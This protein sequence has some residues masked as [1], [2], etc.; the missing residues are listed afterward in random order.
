[1]RNILESM[2]FTD[3]DIA[4]F[5]KYPDNKLNMGKQSYESNAAARRDYILKSC[6]DPYI[7]Q[8]AERIANAA[9]GYA[10]MN[11]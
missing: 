7:G 3:G 2:E 4:N 6:I 10:M 8:W 11:K 9:R 5:F 1:M